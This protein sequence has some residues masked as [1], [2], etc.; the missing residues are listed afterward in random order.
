MPAAWPFADAENTAAITLK[1]IVAGIA[2]ILL[3]THDS[4]DGCWQFL[5]GGEISDEDAS[6][7]AL[8]EI[9]N[10]DPTIEEVADLPFG[11]V[12]E[13]TAVGTSWRRRKWG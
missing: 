5:D 8:R 9:L 4:E 6:V 13:R 11:W 7:V 3:V 1:R 12:A 2:P 10:L